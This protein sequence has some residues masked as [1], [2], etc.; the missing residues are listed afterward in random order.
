MNRFMI[1]RDGN[2]VTSPSSEAL[3]QSSSGSYDRIWFTIESDVLELCPWSSWD[4]LICCAQ[5]FK[6]AL[7]KFKPGG[8]DQF[9]DFRFG[10]WPDGRLIAFRNFTIDPI[11]DSLKL[12]RT[13]AISMN[14]L[15]DHKLFV[16]YQE[17]VHLKGQQ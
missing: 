15:S 11:L 3:N 7:G 16:I 13:L 9:H 6:L 2:Y 12:K 17:Q 10:A 14:L 8:I 5:F 1:L 4:Q